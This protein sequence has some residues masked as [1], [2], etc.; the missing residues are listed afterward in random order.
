MNPERPDQRP[1]L[2]P[3]IR[4][5]DPEQHPGQPNPFDKTL[6]IIVGAA[7]VVIVLVILWLT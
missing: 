4:N 2:Q 5:P 7:V 3:P 6:L 1:G